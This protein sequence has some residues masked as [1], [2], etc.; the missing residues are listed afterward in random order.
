MYW[1]AA[2]N[3]PACARV[4][5]YGAIIFPKYG[6]SPINGDEIS[7]QVQDETKKSK[8]SESLQGDVYDVIRQRSRGKKRFSTKEETSTS[9]ASHRSLEDLRRE[10][11]IP[12]EVLSSLSLS[13]LQKIKKKS[14]I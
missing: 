3:C 13:E 6:E 5:P 2:A 11:N 4:C 12:V 9:N 8:L 10:L 1:Y 7:E 14:L